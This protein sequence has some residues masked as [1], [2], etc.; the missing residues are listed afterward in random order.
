MKLPVFTVYEIY[1][2]KATSLVVEFHWGHRIVVVM[3]THN[4][5]K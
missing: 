3:A 4:C 5:F 2:M 1:L